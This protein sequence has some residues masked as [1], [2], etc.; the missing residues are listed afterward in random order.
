MYHEIPASDAGASYFAVPRRRFAAQLDRMIALGR[1]GTSLERALDE[2]AGRRGLVALTFDDGDETHFSEAWPELRARE[3]SATCFVITTRVGT[4][5]YASWGQL[6]EMAAAGLSIQSHTAT[7]PLL[8][9]LS[10]D[11]VFRELRDSRQRLDDELRQLTCTL[12][13]PGGDMPRGE[14]QHDW[15]L[16]R[17]A[18]YRHVATSAWGPN[19][20]AA[21]FAVHRYTVRR[22][23]PARRLESCIRARSAPTSAEGLRLAAL[24]ALR[25][26]LGAKRYSRWRHG[27]LEKIGR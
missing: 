6:R 20:G 24:G 9:E 8:S 2:G 11:E 25:R 10:H 13:L 1:H 16:V 7:H 17:R 14:R 23:T 19:V 18:G 26:G 5:G 27:L 22:D 15:P 12:A 3:M 21:P 4:A